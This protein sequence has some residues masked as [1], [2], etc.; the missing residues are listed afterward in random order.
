[1]AVLGLALSL[2]LAAVLDVAGLYIVAVAFLGIV[3][4]AYWSS[5][6]DIVMAC[7]AGRHRG[8]CPAPL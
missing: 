5:L 4:A 6:D 2:V 8:R 1:V 3:A 7:P